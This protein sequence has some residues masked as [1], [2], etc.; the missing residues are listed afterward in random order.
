MVRLLRFH[1][2]LAQMEGYGRWLKDALRDSMNSYLEE[3]LIAA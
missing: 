1:Q 3:K 2:H